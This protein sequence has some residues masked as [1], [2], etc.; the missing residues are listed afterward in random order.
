VEVLE[1]AREHAGG[2]P[3]TAHARLV[4]VTARAHLVR[5][6]APLGLARIADAVGPVAVRAHRHVRVPVGEQRLAVH[7]LLI[8]RRDLGVAGPAALIDLD[9]RRGGPAD[10]VRTV[11]IDAGGRLPVALLELLVMNAV[12]DPRVVR[13]MAAL[14]VPGLLDPVVPGGLGLEVGVRRLAEVPMTLDAGGLGV[15]R[16]RQHRCIDLEQDLRAVGER[17]V[18]LGVGVAIEAG[19][20]GGGPG[21]RRRAEA[22]EREREHEL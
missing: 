16:P 13:V 20:V 12:D 2:Q 6:G 7:R 11:A 5:R 10:V 15:L 9:P 3:V 18:V 1:V 22:R 21:T 4:G 8:G 19:L 14:A 17:D